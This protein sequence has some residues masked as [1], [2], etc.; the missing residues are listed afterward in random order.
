M[1]N[2]DDWLQATLFVHDHAAAV[3]AEEAALKTAQ[4]PILPDQC[5]AAPMHAAG[6]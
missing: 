3:A 2:V 1:L 4:A 5:P 6:V